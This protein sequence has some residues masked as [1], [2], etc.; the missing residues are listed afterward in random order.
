MKSKRIQTQPLLIMQ[1][2]PTTQHN[3]CQPNPTGLSPPTR[4]AALGCGTRMNPR[5]SRDMDPRN[6]R[7]QSPRPL[8]L[9]PPRQESCCISVMSPLKSLGF[10]TFPA[11]DT[12]PSA[13]RR[14]RPS[15]PRPE[16]WRGGTPWIPSV[17]WT[18]SR[19]ST[20]ADMGLGQE[21]TNGSPKGG[22]P[23]L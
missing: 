8:N 20:A 6:P 4:R 16:S 2:S 13:G 17:R 15:A 19:V 21:K 1:S 7:P 9:L 11:G 3:P 10:Q 14:R 23:T 18:A 5:S 22:M 12:Q